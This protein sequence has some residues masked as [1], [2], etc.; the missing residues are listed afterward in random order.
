LIVIEGTGANPN[1]L[2]PEDRLIVAFVGAILLVPV[3]I[4]V[5]GLASNFL[6]GK[7]GIIVTVVC[8]FIG[9]AGV[10]YFV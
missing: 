7:V 2:L 4:L 6:E 1:K 8:L 10:C 5:F 3:P 9:G